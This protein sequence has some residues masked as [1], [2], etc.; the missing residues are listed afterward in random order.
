[1]SKELKEGK[2]TLRK[3]VPGRGNTS[4]ALSS[5]VSG[6]FKQQRVVGAGVRGVKGQAKPRAF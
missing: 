1:M 6:I 4:K 2:W 5:S 3:N